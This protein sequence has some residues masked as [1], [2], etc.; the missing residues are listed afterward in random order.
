MSVIEKYLRPSATPHIWCPGCGNGTVLTALLTAIDK[1]GYE[2]KDVVVVSGIGCCSRGSGFIKFNTVNSLHG[3]PLPFATGIKFAN[4]KLHVFVLAG[5]GDTTAI[6]GNHFIH[7]A[8]RNI[9]LTM[10]VVNNEIYG[11]TGGQY[12][13][14]TPTGAK[15]TS[16]VYGNV[17]HP[18]DICNLAQAAGATYVARGT[19]YNTNQLTNLIIEGA[20]NKGFSVVEAVAQC[21]TS[22]GRRNKMKTPASMLEWQRDHAVPVA[23]AAKMTTEELADKFLVGKLSECK[24]PEYTENYQKLIDELHSKG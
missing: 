19:V 18:F 15:S 16:S 6:G 14:T 13:P 4:P 17:E 8:R 23:A 9:D 21:P 2:Q 7:A 22:F 11:M 3:R 1:L 10:I 5:D 20:Q 24:R 12:S